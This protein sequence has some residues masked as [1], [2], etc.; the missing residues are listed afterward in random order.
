MDT[1]MDK[2]NPLPEEVNAI[3]NLDYSLSVDDQIH[4]ITHN[5]TVTNGKLELLRD[6]E[7]VMGK[8]LGDRRSVPENNRT[9]ALHRR[10]FSREH[11]EIS[12]RLRKLMS[13]SVCI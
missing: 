1:D 11:F 5:S 3:H 9:S 6:G 7:D 8:I 10:L 12:G 13:L 2:V 4:G